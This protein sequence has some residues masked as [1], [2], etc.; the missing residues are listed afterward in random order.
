MR[1][2]VI[3]ILLV[4]IILTFVFLIFLYNNPKIPVLCYH[5]VAT[6]E[7]KAAF[8]EEDDWTITVD[9]FEEHLKY[10]KKHHYKTLTMDE[11][12]NW[13]IGNLKLPYKSVLITFDDGFLSNY[14]YAFDL[15]KKY[16]MNATVFV[17]GS[18]IDASNTSSWNGNI[19]TY[20][21]KEILNNLENEYPNIEIYSHSYNLHYQGA[22]NQEEEALQN[23]I[24]KFNEFYKDTKF[25]C[26]PFGQYN[27]KMENAL[28][29][30]GYKL[31]FRYGP[32]K[33]DYKKA[34]RNDSNYEIPRLNVSHG[35]EV[36]KFGLRLLKYN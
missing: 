7:E 3:F 28:E 16:D 1:K 32:N 21:T 20:M 30:S 5:N 8:P 14:H 15:L 18:F 17:V 34:S 4:I 9:N 10:L 6:Q 2:I 35:M 25:Y 26:Y 19:K 29:K 31:A 22:I 24:N 36:F 27:D 12:Y 33:K 13:K 23:D 11:F